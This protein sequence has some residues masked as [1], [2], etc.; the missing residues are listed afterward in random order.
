MNKIPTSVDE[1]I[2]GFPKGVQKILKQV[3]LVVK[4]AAPDAEEGISYQMPY[5]K[6]NGRLL[7]FAAHTAHLG[8]YPMTTG[9]KAFQPELEPYKWAKGS[10]QF[11]YNK[12]LPLVLITKMVRFRVK[13]NLEKEKGK[14]K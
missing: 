5:Y 4:K 7:Y 11:P 14:K 12:P 9:I 3:R 2:A 8:F 13:E 6:Q 1:Y 10:V